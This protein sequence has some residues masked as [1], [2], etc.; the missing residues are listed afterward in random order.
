MPDACDHGEYIAHVK[1]K[2]DESWDIQTWLEHAHGVSELAGAFASKFGNEDWG[3]Y[4]GLIHDTGKLLPDWQRYIRKETGYGMVEKNVNIRKVYHSTLGAFLPVHRR[5]LYPIIEKAMAYITM[6]HHAGLP[7]YTTGS[8]AS[9]K[10]RFYEESEETPA[11]LTPQKEE[12][13]KLEKLLKTSSD[14]GILEVLDAPLPSSTPAALTNGNIDCEAFALWIRMLFSCLVDADRL[15]TERFMDKEKSEKRGGYSSI[16]ELKQRFDIFIDEKTAKAE[17]SKINS[18]RANILASCRNKAKLPPGFFTLSVPTGAG[19]TLASMAFALNHAIEHNKDRIIIAIPY[20][21]IIEQTAKVYKYGSDNPEEIKQGKRLLGE[22]NVIE[23][24]CNVD[25]GG[26]GEYEDFSSAGEKLLRRRLTAENWDA[27]V[28]VTTNVQLFESLAASKPSK[29]RKLHNIANSVIILDEAQMLPPDYLKS[30]VET[31]KQLVRHFN[32]TVVLCTATQPALKNI[33]TGTARLAG[34][35]V[36]TELADEDR[37]GMFNEFK[38]VQFY[39]PKKQDPPPTWKDLAEE[40]CEYESVLCVVNTRKSARDLHREMPEGCMHLSALMCAEDRSDVI[41]RVKE[42]L[43]NKEPVRLISTQLIEA[44]VDI[45]FPV[46]YRAYS[47]IDSLVQAAGRCNRE[48]KS[49]TYGKVVVFEAPVKPPIGLLRKGAEAARSVLDSVDTFEPSDELFK[50][51]FEYYYSVINT[52]DKPLFDKYMLKDSL[53]GEF[54]F[55]TYAEKYKLIDDT[56]QRSIIV[57]YCSTTSSNSSLEMLEQLKKGKPMDRFLARK[58]Q[59]FTITLPEST[60]FEMYKNGYS[61]PINESGWAR[62][63]TKELYRGGIGLLFGDP[64]WSDA[65]FA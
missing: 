31:M 44:G 27:P 28:I 15:D 4:Y 12:A 8:G 21:S 48:G 42:K 61:I 41:A 32:V 5:R 50:E 24:H 36:S 56:N 16:A 65:F 2:D 51:Y 40:L 62:L 59:R 26:D 19:K 52:I 14:S 57:P 43:T 34:I 46:V 49:T 9:L 20:T 63:Q 54:Q 30:I 38:R 10:E 47:G 39:L 25:T 13:A 60:W 29:C 17:P 23:H 64:T 22:E 45:D 18:L 35:D 1:Q 3:K 58:L 33:G 37:K 53:H 55:R 6:G 11:L 7:D